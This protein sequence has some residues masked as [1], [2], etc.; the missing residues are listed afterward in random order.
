MLRITAPHMLGMPE[1][2]FAAAARVAR[3]PAWRPSSCVYLPPPS[4]LWHTTAFTPARA[5]PTRGNLCSRSSLLLYLCGWTPSL[6]RFVWFL[7]RTEG[8]RRGSILVA[9]R[10]RIL[11]SLPVLCHLLRCAGARYLRVLPPVNS[12]SWL[13]GVCADPAVPAYSTVPLQPHLQHLDGAS[14]SAAGRSHSPLPI[15]CRLEEGGATRTR[16]STFTTIYV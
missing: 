15:H 6:L 8:V 7:S 9:Y 1:V 3:L 16:I 2:A 14:R 4:V 5:A 12:A 10:S 11:L 13:R